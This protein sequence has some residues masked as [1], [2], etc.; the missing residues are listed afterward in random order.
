[1]QTVLAPFWGSGKPG[2]LPKFS[3]QSLWFLSP[4]PYRLRTKN[5]AAGIES[6]LEYPQSC[7]LYS[8]DLGGQ[9]GR[10][11]KDRKWEQKPWKGFYKAILTTLGDSETIYTPPQ[12]AEAERSC[13]WGQPRLSHNKIMSQTKMITMEALAG[14]NNHLE[15]SPPQTPYSTDKLGIRLFFLPPSF[16]VFKLRLDAVVLV[17]DPSILEAEVG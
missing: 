13:V 12:E 6:C 11:Q 15:T 1:M 17:G 2:K 9:K 14:I 16:D 10:K 3:V 5:R 4:I 8:Q 7:G